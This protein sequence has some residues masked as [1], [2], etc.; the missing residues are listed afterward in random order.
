MIAESKPIVFEIV[1]S[2]SNSTVC[3]YLQWKRIIELCLISREKDDQLVKNPP[4]Q[5]MTD[6]W[7][8]EDAMLF[9]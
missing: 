6:D 4:K 1:S 8:R 2:S 5:M 3:D 9:E 7:K